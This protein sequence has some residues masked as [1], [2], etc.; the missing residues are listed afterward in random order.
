MR[1]YVRQKLISLL[2]VLLGITLLAFVLG[3]LTPGN[4]AELALSQGGY[5]PTPAQIA[6]MEEQMGLNAPY[7]VQYLRWLGRALTGDLGTSYYSGT[8]VGEELLRRLPVTGALTAYAMALTVGAGVALGCAAAAWYGR[9]PDRLLKGLFHIPLSIPAFWLALLLILLFAETLGWLPT[10]GTGGPRHMLL[11][12]VSL[13]AASAAMTG[14][15]TRSALL[16]ELG[17]PYCTA[18]LARGIRRWR[19]VVCNALPNAI[20][21]VTAMLGNTL[22]GM[23]G[24]SI[25]VES[26]FALPGIGSYALDAVSHRDYPALRGYVLVTGGLYVLIT[27]LV[28]VI[29]LLLDPRVRLE[30]RAL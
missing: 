23:L 24:G 10:S 8:P 20:V 27:L 12:A 5:E 19:L 13:A 22:G 6:E 30:G 17:R 14:R 25:V 15:L 11:P 2:P 16:A 29:S 3:A 26:I 1:G 7:P 4:P 21:P 28:D 18:A 9:W